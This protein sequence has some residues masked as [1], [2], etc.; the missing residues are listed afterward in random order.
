[1][2][3]AFGKRLLASKGR[4]Y[5]DRNWATAATW[6]QSRRPFD[7]ARQS[8]TC[9]IPPTEE[10]WQGARRNVPEITPGKIAWRARPRH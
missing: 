2:D 6:A 8:Y 5:P 4:R 9:E 10:P 7:P 1:V 3:D